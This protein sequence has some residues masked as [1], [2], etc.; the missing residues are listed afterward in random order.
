MRVE[1]FEFELSPERI[2]LRPA[3]PRDS[4]RLLIVDQNGGRNHA[5]LSALPD[6]LTAGDVLVVN[7]S[8]V[9]LARL[10]DRNIEILACKIEYELNLTAFARGDGRLKLA[11]KSNMIAG[12]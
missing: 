2:A 10:A 12:A 6:F 3:V 4:A 5:R 9:I 7:D 11:I 8:K 1:L